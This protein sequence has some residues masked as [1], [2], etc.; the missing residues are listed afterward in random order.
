MLP[1]SGDSST[2]LTCWLP[3]QVSVP[4]GGPVASF[5]DPAARGQPGGSQRQSTPA[6]LAA[7]NV[8][9][10]EESA[11][12]APRRCTK[13][14]DRPHQ[15]AMAGT[16]PCSFQPK[17]ALLTCR[18]CRAPGQRLA[19]PR[20]PELV[21]GAAHLLGAPAGD[22]RGRAGCQ[23][24]PGLSASTMGDQKAR[25]KQRPRVQP[26][27]PTIRLC[28]LQHPSATHRHHRRSRCWCSRHPRTRRSSSRKAGAGRQ[29]S[30]GHGRR[31][32]RTQRP[33][34]SCTPARV[35]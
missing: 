22:C 10:A 30:L 26:P 20:A 29:Q 11:N 12:S 8:R 4:A 16:Q 31:R 33:R 32:V 14:A 21:A 6:E 35:E 28:S 17:P 2:E 24:W 23:R 34:A 1:C 5:T 18:A 15:P 9:T 19:L 27:R 25:V 3:I 13:R 7:A